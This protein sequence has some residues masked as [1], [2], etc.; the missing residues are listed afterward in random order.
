MCLKADGRRRVQGCL[1]FNWLP[2]EDS[3]LHHDRVGLVAGRSIGGAVVRNRAK[4][5]LREVFRL[6]RAEL[7]HPV[8]AVLVARKSIVGKSFRDVEQ[9]FQ[10][11]LRHSRLL[12]ETRATVPAVSGVSEPAA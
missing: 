8:S 6:H 3:G 2:A 5:L 12:K 4:R 7:V 10:T 1:I 11:A 9:D